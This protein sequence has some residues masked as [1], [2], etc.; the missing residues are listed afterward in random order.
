VPDVIRERARATAHTRTSAYQNAL[1]AGVSITAGTDSGTTFVPH[2]ALATEIRLLHEGGLSVRQ[3]LASATWLAA[4]EVG[5]PGV[6]GTLARGA[7]ADLLIV[8][9]DPLQDLA[10]LEN[11]AEVILAGTPTGG[12]MHGA[13]RMRGT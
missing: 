11:V 1:D 2:G 5:L 13:L 9:G 3:A 10:A 7:Y 8:E 4:S 12:S 6:I